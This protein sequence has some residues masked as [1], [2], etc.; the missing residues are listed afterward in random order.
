[1]AKRALELLALPKDCPPL[2][3]L[4]VGCGTGLSGQAL[5]QEGHHWV[6]LDIS[7]AMLRIA[8]D[9]ETE[10]ELVQRDIGE[11]LPFRPGVFDGCI[12]I[13]ALQWL[14][15]ADKRHHVPQRRLKCFFMSLFACLRRGARAVF[16]FYPA[17]KQQLDMIVRSS[18]RSGFTGGLV[19][20]FPHSTRAKKYFLVLF[21]GPA[22]AFTVP[23][24]K[25]GEVM[26]AG[27]E[28]DSEEEDEE[29]EEGDSAS[30]EEDLEGE[31]KPRSTEFDC[32]P[33]DLYTTKKKT[34]HIT[35]RQKKRKKTGKVP[36]SRRE[37]VQWKK[38]QLRSKGKR[39]ANDSKYT[40]RKRKERF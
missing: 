30:M 35:E 27:D 36:L 37:W 19:V 12:S 4:D 8:V 2:L 33:G 26:S 14:C 39:T 29:S 1:M 17:N 23:R 11:G 3:L 5:E 18:E 13:S 9:R 31:A 16:Q 25:T 34:V 28:E 40:A 6:G 24:A 20:D 10:G 21:A 22:S 32:A 7:D 15:N 38:E